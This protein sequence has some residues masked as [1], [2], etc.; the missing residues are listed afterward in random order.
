M[1]LLFIRNVSF[2]IHSPHNTPIKKKKPSKSNQIKRE[3][4]TSPM[5]GGKQGKISHWFAQ[6]VFGWKLAYTFFS[7]LNELKLTPEIVHS[8]NGDGGF[9]TQIFVILWMKKF[10]VASRLTWKLRMT[11]TD[12]GCRSHWNFVSIFLSATKFN[13]LLHFV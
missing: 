11:R 2:T 8:T 10:W 1:S 5:K 6:F 13:E 12:V 4:S 9:Q 3:V 7:Q